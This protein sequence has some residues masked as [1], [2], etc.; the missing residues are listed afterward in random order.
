MRKAV[1]LIAAVAL[2]AG[3]A[4]AQM[5]KPGTPQQPPTGTGTL[6]VTG[7]NSRQ[8][9][10]AAPASLEQARKITTAEALRMQKAGEAV[11]VDVRSNSQFA[12]GHIRGA[13]SIPGSQLIQRLRELPPQKMIITYCACSAEQSS[14]RAVLDL[15]AHGVQNTAAMTGGWNEWKAK[16]FPTAT[17]PK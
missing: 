13:L 8:A 9:T 14:A 17:G 11:I 5:K 3:V 2:V 1:T 12:L 15:N 7:P 4:G 10:Q 16:G 6:K